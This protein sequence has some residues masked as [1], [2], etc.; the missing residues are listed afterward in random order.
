MS[1]TGDL[2]SG[3]S[4]KKVQQAPGL[5]IYVLEGPLEY[6]VAGQPPRT[7]RAG[8]TLTAPAG[9]VHSVR[10]VCSRR[11]AELA[12]YVAGKAGHRA[13]RVRAA[14]AAD[15]RP[16]FPARENGHRS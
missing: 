14:T 11:A 12:T 15:C 16:G 4:G 1:T 7:R 8:K 5:R 3:A 10:N 2:S 6:Q 13:G 9:A